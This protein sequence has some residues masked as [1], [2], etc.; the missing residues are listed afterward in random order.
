MPQIKWE[1]Q[2][3]CRL[4]WERRERSRVGVKF[5]GTK[6]WLRK[7]NRGR[8]TQ[9]KYGSRPPL[10]EE[11]PPSLWF[12]PFCLVQKLL[13]KMIELLFSQYKNKFFNRPTPKE[14]GERP[15]Q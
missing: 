11:G 5:L 4:F 3:V 1:W 14:H 12:R 2:R 9:R 10:Q 8:G 7:R 15:T 13:S 6:S